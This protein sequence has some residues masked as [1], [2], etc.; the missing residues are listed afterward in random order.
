MTTRIQSTPHPHAALPVEGS[1]SLIS[2]AR[3]IEIYAAML[4]C[5]MLRERVRTLAGTAKQRAL[6]AGCEAVAAAVLIGLRAEDSLISSAPHLCAA[7]LKGV[8]LTRLLRPFLA[9]GPA[10]YPAA[11][12]WHAQFDAGVLVA[13]SGRA[14]DHNF[15]AGAMAAGA[16]FAARHSKREDV[17]VAF[18]EENSAQDAWRKIFH[19]ALAHDLP[20]IFVRQSPRPLSPAWRRNRF[21]NS[22]FGN[23]PIIPVDSN[24]AVAVYRVAHEAIAHARRGSGPTLLDCV[25]LRLAGERKRESDCIIRMEGYLKAKNLRPDRIKTGVAAKFSRAFDAAIFAARRDVAKRGKNRGSSG[26]GR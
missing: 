4:K 8:P 17:A 15:A 12:A 21:G 5:R 9:R 16:A 25:S 22:I 11:G 14:A 18:Y 13:P 24:D 10:A 7:L 6:T 20:L 23:L 2:D 1:G 19:F 26:S 3:L